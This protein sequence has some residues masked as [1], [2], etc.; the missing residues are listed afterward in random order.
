MGIDMNNP[1]S[2]RCGYTWPEDHEFADD[3]DNQSCCYRETLSGSN[4]CLWHA[5][6]TV[7]GKTTDALE[8]SVESEGKYSPLFDG[9]ILHN[10]EINF[11][12]SNLSFR[13]SKARNVVF[14]E[15]N[16]KN[17]DFRCADLFNVRF[18]RSMLSNASFRHANLD[19]AYIVHS[20]L[21]TTNFT[22]VSMQDSYLNAPDFCKT[23]FTQA[24]LSDATFLDADLSDSLFDNA[25][26]SNTVFKDTNLSGASL[27]SS[28]LTNVNF[29]DSDLYAANLK[30]AILSNVE[31]VGANLTDTQLQKADLSGVNLTDSALYNANLRKTNLTATQLKGVEL[32]NANLQRATLTDALLED[33]TMHEVDL[34]NAVLVRT[35]LFDADL[36]DCKPHGASFV[37][38][39]IN[40]GTEFGSPDSKWWQNWLFSPKSRCAYDPTNDRVSTSEN[41]SKIKQS[42]AKAAD[43]Y[44]TFEEIARDN[45]QPGRQSKMFVRRQEMQRQLEFHDRNYGKWAFS[46]I[47]SLLFNY[48]ESL[49][50]IF[51]WGGLIILA[52]GIVYWQFDLIIGADGEFITNF[53]DSLYFSTLT[54]STLG[55]GDFQPSPASTLARGL[56]LSQ[57]VGGAVIIAIFVFVLGRR[58][59]R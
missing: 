13:D 58:A 14:R 8:R 18:E 59:A 27:V 35:N 42:L 54:F 53:I 1:A 39:Q 21:N 11:D 24:D 44:Q 34:E 20:D 12:I 38:V 4:Q 57:A 22:K 43:T 7:E 37:D 48:G 10:L 56:V 36:T 23:I 40:S 49:G 52:Y 9:A 41:D 45:A 2:N 47:S 55:M 31:L 30:K 50:R 32:T 16:L 17:S 5:E 33:A 6:T 28:N 29:E 15:A 3:P 51:A 26:L 19:E 46:W 25:N